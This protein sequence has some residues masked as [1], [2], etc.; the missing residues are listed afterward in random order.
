[1]NERCKRSGEDP[2]IDE[3]T[4]HQTIGLRVANAMRSAVFHPVP[5]LMINTIAL[6]PSPRSWLLILNYLEGTNVV[7]MFVNS[8][9][10]WF[11]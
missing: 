1:M 7:E 8:L 5:F 11:A 6:L 9:R 10:W 2:L 3:K 4:R